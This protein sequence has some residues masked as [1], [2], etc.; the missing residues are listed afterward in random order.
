VLRGVVVPVCVVVAL[1]GACSGDDETATATGNTTVNGGADESIPTGAECEAVH[2]LLKLELSENERDAVQDKVQ[3]LDGVTATELRSPAAAEGEPPVL[4]VTTESE[5]A[6]IGVAEALSG[7]PS[8]VSVVHPEQ[9][10]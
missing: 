7:D 1:A 8:V 10:C 4:L 5:E 6:A 3:N 9:V 2:V